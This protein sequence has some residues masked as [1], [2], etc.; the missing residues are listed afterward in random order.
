MAGISHDV[1]MLHWVLNRDL[2]FSFESC[3]FYGRKCNICVG[4]GQRSGLEYRLTLPDR[5]NMRF[6]N[7]HI[8]SYRFRHLT[9]TK[10]P[11]K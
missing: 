8:T 4:Y 3:Q 7:Y 6:A 5:Q 9:A 2:V 10:L 11:R 1:W